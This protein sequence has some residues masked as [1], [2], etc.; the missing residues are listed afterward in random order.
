MG[1]YQ[2]MYKSIFL[3]IYLKRWSIFSLSNYLAEN[4]GAP[5]KQTIVIHLWPEAAQLKHYLFCPDHI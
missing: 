4:G 5:L 2:C 1:I 3:S